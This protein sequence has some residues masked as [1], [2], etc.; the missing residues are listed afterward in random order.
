[1]IDYNACTKDRRKRGIKGHENE[2]ECVPADRQTSAGR[3][4][5]HKEPTLPFRQMHAAAGAEMAHFK[6]A[7]KGVSDETHREPKVIS[8]IRSGLELK[9]KAVRRKSVPSGSGRG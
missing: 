1:M 4:F 7:E 2:P 9:Q 5:A 3:H 6:L 8:H